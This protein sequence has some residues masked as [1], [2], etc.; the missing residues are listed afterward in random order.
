MTPSA[1]RSIIVAFLLWACLT[2]SA[3]A[4]AIPPQD[5]VQLPPNEFAPPGAGSNDAPG[6]MM[7]GADPFMLLENN[8]QVQVDLGLSEDQIR[9]LSHSGQLFR[10]Q[11]Q[12]LAR[13]T[14]VSSKAEIER[15]IW[16]SRDTIVHLL[17]PEQLQRL[18]Q[19]MLQIHGPCLAIS[20]THFSQ[21]LGLSEMQLQKMVA[22]CRQ[23]TMNMREAFRPPPSGEDPCLTLRTNRAQLEQ[24]RTEGQAR[25][26]ALLSAPQQ[27][28][29]QEM[30]GR[31]LTLEPVMPPQCDHRMN[32]VPPDS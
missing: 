20:D 24:L 32:M 5:R 8:R 12:E 29:L 16:T 21:D 28:R 10:S 13:A 15:Q 25:V 23:V 19:I 11:L 2:P 4:Q 9:R 1:S 17:T 27:R 6:G 26:V 30:Q 18:Q 22:T 3:F 14:N 31:K 7:P